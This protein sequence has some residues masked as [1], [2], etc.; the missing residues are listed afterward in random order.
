MTHINKKDQR[1]LEEKQQRKCYLYFKDCFYDF[2]FNKLKQRDSNIMFAFNK[3]VDKLNKYAT[4]G[5]NKRY[6]SLMIYLNFKLADEKKD[7]TKLTAQRMAIKIYLYKHNR[8]YN[9]LSPDY[10]ALSKKFY[11]WNYGNLP[12]TPQKHYIYKCSI[13]GQPMAVFEKKLPNNNT[14]IGSTKTPWH[15]NKFIDASQ[16]FD[17]HGGKVHQGNY[18]FS[19]YD[20]LTNSELQKVLLIMQ[21]SDEFTKHFTDNKLHYVKN[22]N[23][24]DLDLW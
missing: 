8:P 10:L 22:D 11:L 2:Y 9:E 17:N 5:Y 6:H 24:D 23:N 4:F 7:L 16:S 15:N 21:R 12:E 3:K 1:T 14:L 18:A 20:E 13:C 19:G